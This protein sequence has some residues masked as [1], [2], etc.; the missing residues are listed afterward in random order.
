VS[1]EAKQ[2]LNNALIQSAQFQA[3]R[4]TL[5]LSQEE[6]LEAVSRQQRRQARADQQFDPDQYLRQIAQSEKTTTTNVGR[7]ELDGLKF[8]DDDENDAGFGQMQDDLQKFSANDRGYVEDEETGDLRRARLTDEKP[9]EMGEFTGIGTKRNSYTDKLFPAEYTREEPLGYVGQNAPKTALVDALNALNSG[10]SQYGY[11]AFPGSVDVASNLEQSIG[12]MAGGSMFTGPRGT[13]GVRQGTYSVNK[14]IDLEAERSLASD[15]IIQD[16]SNYNPRMRAENDEAVGHLA[17]TIARLGYTVNG[18]GAMADE[19]IG[20]IG[21]IRRLGAAGSLGS[22]EQTQVIRQGPQGTFPNAEE[23][24]DNTGRIVG[25]ADPVTKAP[26]ALDPALGISLSTQGANTPD[27]A[28]MMNAPQNPQTAREWAASNL[29]AMVQDTGST[30]PRY[31]QANISK[32]TTEYSN[33]LN[34]MLKGFGLKSAPNVRLLDEIDLVANEVQKRLQAKGKTLFVKDEFDNNIPAGTQV[35]SG[36]MNKLNMTGGDEQRLANSLFQLDAARRSSVN[37]NPTGTYLGRTNT[38]VKQPQISLSPDSYKGVSR[39]TA[40]ALVENERRK[41]SGVEFDSPSEGFGSI[42]IAQQKGGTRG[43]RGTR[44]EPGSGSDA[45]QDIKKR[46]GKLETSG[47]QKPYIG[48]PAQRSTSPMSSFGQQVVYNNTG[49][50]DPAMIRSKLEELSESRAKKGESRADAAI[51]RK[52]NE[53]NIIG[54]QAVERRANE[55]R[56]QRL[57]AMREIM[58]YIPANR[59]RNLGA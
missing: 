24:V 7:Q 3:A 20:R 25:Y 50:S 36:L 1:L 5:G 26:I 8:L 57:G 58:R 53:S 39:G 40:Q 44:G 28:Q 33:K 51:R 45:E 32:E 21:E 42:Q 13:S 54:A 10:T 41:R 35:V 11:E 59:R 37:Q 56:E 27:S 43:P 52:R 4:Q 55:A 6:M 2:A 14:P 15:L 49:E 46:L 18:P 19:A 17:D 38:P 31:P 9:V 47:A 48:L 23:I 34:K 29:P 30:P 12:G 22:M 16:R